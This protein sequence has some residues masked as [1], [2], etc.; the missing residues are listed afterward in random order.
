MLSTLRK[1]SK[2]IFIKTF[3]ILLALAFVLWGVGDVVRGGSANTVAKVGKK[4]ISVSDFQNVYNYEVG[5]IQQMLGKE[6]TPEQIAALKIKE[7]LVSQLVNKEL[8]T[9]KAEDM[10]ITLGREKAKELI[11]SNPAFHNEQG[12]FDKAKYINI[13]RKNGVNEAQHINALIQTYA[14]ENI[15]SSLFATPFVSQSTLNYIYDYENESRKL[16]LI[17][18]PSA[19]DS[20]ILEPSETNLLEFY[21]QSKE[22]YKIPEKRDIVYIEVAPGNFPDEIS[23]TDEELKTEYEARKSEFS[24]DEQRNVKQYTFNNQQEAQ[25][26]YELLAANKKLEGKS[27]IPLGLVEKKTLPEELQDIIF[28]LKANIY[29]NPFKSSFGWHVFIVSEVI[30]PATKSFESVKNDLRKQ[31][32]ESK[33]SNIYSEIRNQVEDELAE[34]KTLENISQKYN[35]VLHELK[36]VT[37]SEDTM[38]QTKD[39]ALKTIIPEAFSLD[40]QLESP[41]VPLPGKNAF[42]IIKVKTIYPERI[43]AMDEIKGALIK[44]W[45]KEQK[46]KNMIETASKIVSEIKS[47]KNVDK[48]IEK[49]QATS[50]TATY[51]RPTQKEQADANFEVLLKAFNTAKNNI[52][53]PSLTK[54][55][56][57]VVALVKDVSTPKNADEERIKRIESIL[58][59]KSLNDLMAQYSLYLKSQYPVEINQENIA[60]F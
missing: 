42:A 24:T 50:S 32:Q 52:T 53:E 39:E 31:L 21:Q 19:S 12:K 13:L 5:R 3:L 45:K 59:E 28:S 8:F 47:G 49:Y 36:G 9:L 20:E 22:A 16:Q 14:S 54:K 26:A 35:I 25:K 38:K 29:S 41:A 46:K 34:G 57:V 17:K 58:L 7:N 1:S 18:I 33:L 51:N 43:Q 30:P 60:A 10:G 11:K 15:I 40:E 23:V 48:T 44:A 55:G 2:N 4:S 6:I 27:I 56:E 37:L